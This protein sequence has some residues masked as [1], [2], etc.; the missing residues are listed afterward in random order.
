MK[1]LYFL[2]VLVLSWSCTELKS[3]CVVEKWNEPEH[4]YTTFIPMVTSTGKSSSVILIPY[5]IHDNADYCVRVEGVSN[6][7][8]TITQT[9]FVNALE[10]DTISVGDFVCI[11]G[12]CDE[13]TNN[14]KTRVKN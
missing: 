4:S 5:F 7:G 12:F 10:Y 14:I 3:G 1:T 6:E 11:D 13:D 9:F 2:L 8:D